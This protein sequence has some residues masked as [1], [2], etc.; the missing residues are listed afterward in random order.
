M[1]PLADGS[2]GVLEFFEA[3]RSSDRKAFEKV[4]DRPAL[5]ADLRDQIADLGRK[6][7]LG[8]EG[9][10]SEFTLDRLITPDAFD[11][12]DT[13]TGQPLTSPPSLS[14]VANALQIRDRGHVCLMTMTTRTCVLQFT[15]REGVWRLTGMPARHTPIALPHYPP[16]VP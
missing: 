7:G 4:I 9:G 10:A 8:V 11:L 14:Q 12:V 16:G 3:A 6:N 5:R 1:N 15:R 2:R 13:K